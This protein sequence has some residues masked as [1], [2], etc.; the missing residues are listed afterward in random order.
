MRGLA[1]PA[2]VVLGSVQAAG[3]TIEALTQSGD[4]ARLLECGKRHSYGVKAPPSIDSAIRLRCAAARLGSGKAQFRLGELRAGTAAG[5]KDE[6][7]AASWRLKAA[8]AKYQAAQ[9][10]RHRPVH[11]STGGGRKVPTHQRTCR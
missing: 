2:A 3:P 7:L 9:A 8:L 6:V 10:T 4:S 1:L 11:L 5:K